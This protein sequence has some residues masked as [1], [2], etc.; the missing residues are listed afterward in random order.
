MIRA[1]ISLEGAALVRVKG[2]LPTPS[3]YIQVQ[4]NGGALTC[5]DSTVPGCSLTCIGTSLQEKRWRALWEEV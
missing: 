2:I 4:Y 3:G 1:G 5:A